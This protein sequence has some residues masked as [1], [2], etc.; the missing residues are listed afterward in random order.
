M[1]SEDCGN[2]FSK[3]LAI[4]FITDFDLSEW[5]QS[6]LSKE[7]INPAINWNT[8]KVPEPSNKT[9]WQWIYN[10]SQKH[11]VCLQP[12]TCPLIPRF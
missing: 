2:I 10:H 9:S 8:L 1:S 3:E 6:C 7:R 11:P 4:I 5:N 12:V